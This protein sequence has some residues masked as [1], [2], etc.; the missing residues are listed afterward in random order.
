MSI[1]VRKKIKS[2]KKTKEE[3]RNEDRIRKET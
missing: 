1:G 3:R 2:H